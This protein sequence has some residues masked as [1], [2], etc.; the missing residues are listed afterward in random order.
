MMLQ[1]NLPQG[2]FQ[3]T[4]GI[5][6]DWGSGGTPARK[7]PSYYNGTVPWIKTGDLGPKFINDTSEYISELGVQHS[8][9]KYFPKG[10]VAIA[11]YGATIGKTS[12]L[13]IDAT[14]NQACG[15]GFPVA[16]LTFSEYL[17]YFLLNE[18]DNF[19]AKGKGGAQPNISQTL[20]KEHKDSLI[21][22]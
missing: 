4:L 18:K 19:I 16:G 7:E 3:T 12:I 5:V 11:M 14:T 13:G 15:V 17:Y 6:A 2:W 20:I 9:A 10:S 1:G 8:S 22:S 21:N